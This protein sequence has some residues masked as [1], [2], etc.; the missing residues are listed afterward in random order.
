LIE[1][2]RTQVAR[3]R[4]RLLN[5]TAGMLA[6]VLPELEQ[7]VHLL[8]QCEQSEALVSPAISPPAE[9][10]LYRESA[11]RLGHELAQVKALAK[12]ANEFYSMRIRLLAPSDSS[13]SYSRNGLA[14]GSFAEI[15]A[16]APQP[17]GES[18]LHG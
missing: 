5:P 13:V 2:V 8:R 12:Q 18:V 17:Q 6:Q 3:V 1:E 15:A 11:R 16:E 9:E 10:S 7:A 4:E 14:G